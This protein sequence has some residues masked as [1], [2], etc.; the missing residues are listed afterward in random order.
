[1]QG[2][3]T[4]NHI[5]KSLRYQEYRAF[6]DRLLEED[7]TTGAKQSPRLVEFTRLNVHRMRRLDK[8]AVLD[9][10]FVDKLG[11]VTEKW[12]WLV[13]TEAWCGD[14]AQILPVLQKAT[15]ISPNIT[16]RLLF[17]D[18]NPEVMDAYLTGGGR[19]VP[20]LICLKADTLEEIGVWGPR[21]APAQ[22]MVM[23]YKAN[24]NIPYDQ[25]SEDVQRWYTKNKA[26]TLQEE[27]T[28]LLDEW[29][30]ISQ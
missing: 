6:I 7:K 3:I 20:K 23:D 9:Q 15:E 17:R 16:L 25:L 28:K 11:Q 24:P 1:M 14:A 4:S 21:P 8:T 19:A 18:E 5:E 29:I 27:F 2:V 22:Q 30:R 12:I 10:N 26:V 13:I